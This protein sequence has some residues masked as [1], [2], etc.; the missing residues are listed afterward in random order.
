MVADVSSGTT[1]HVCLS[2][3]GAVLFSGVGVF[4]RPAPRRAIQS[5]L[6]IGTRR[7][8]IYVMFWVLIQ[9][10]FVYVIVQRVY[11]LAAGV[12]S[13][14]FCAPLTHVCVR[15]RV[16]AC[17]CVHVHTRALSTVLLSLQDMPASSCIFP[18]PVL[19]SA[20]PPRGP[21]S[22]E[23]GPRDQ[24]PGTRVLTATAESLLLGLL[25]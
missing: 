24:D 25:G 1:P 4:A 10:C 17:V 22:L 8:D 23:D 21:G 2:V 5:F 6:H 16:R 15:V 20:V 14:G 11:A 12:L 9:Y 3:P 7:I 13:T 19:K 18:V